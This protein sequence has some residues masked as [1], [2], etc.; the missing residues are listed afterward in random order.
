MAERNWQE[1]EEEYRAG[2]VSIGAICRKHD[3]SRNALRA[4]ATKDGWN[5]V[6]ANEVRDEVTERLTFAENPPGEDAVTKAAAMQVEAILGQRKDIAGLRELVQK[7]SQSLKRILDGEG[8]ERDALTLGRTGIVGAIDTLGSVMQRLIPMERAALG[9][10]APS[11]PGTSPTGP[12]GSPDEAKPVVTFYL[13]A[14]HRN[15]EA[16]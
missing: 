10:D 6:F 11:A 1:I 5:R 14:N 9:I 15:P 3:I 16:E 2:V 8:E 7:S 13:P 12:T 4:R